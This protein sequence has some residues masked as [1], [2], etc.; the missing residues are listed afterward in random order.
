MKG[1][2]VTGDGAEAEYMTPCV[3]RAEYTTPFERRAHENK[4]EDGTKEKD[5]G[6]KRVAHRESKDISEAGPRKKSLAILEDCY[7]HFWAYSV[8]QMPLNV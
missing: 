1:G 4:L 6:S 3:R 7:T 2:F 8:R 5:R